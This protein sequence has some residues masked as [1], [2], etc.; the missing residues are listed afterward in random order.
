MN[1][2]YIVAPLVGGVIGYVTNDLAIRMLFRPHTAKYLFGMHLPFTPGIIPKEK[3]RIAQAIGEVI[4]EN[5]MNQEV[6][7]QYLL[8]DGMVSKLR[9]TVTQFVDSQRTNPETVAQSL[10]RYLSDQEIQ[11]VA[12]D[13]N[14]NL[15]GQIHGKISDPTVGDSVAHLAMQR[16]IVSLSEEGLDDSLL[17]VPKLLGKRILGSILSALQGPAERMLSKNIHDILQNNGPEIVS[18][19][20]GSEVQNLLD[21]PVEQLLQGKDALLDKVPDK[22][23]ELYRMTITEHLPKILQTLDISKIVC[24]RINEMDMVETE[25]IILQVMKKELRAIVWLGAGLGFLLGFVN[26]FIK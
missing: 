16:V 6:L 15:T 7:Q 9:T 10:A 17:G 20:I 23:E 2:A 22:A 3:S 19:L 24:D 12:D 4:S 26:A 5:L 8:S 25:R 1:L 21:T 18:N 14:R 11:G 13:I